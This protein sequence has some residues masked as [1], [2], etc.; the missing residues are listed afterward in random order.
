MNFN[1]DLIDF[2]FRLY[3]FL[4]KKNTHKNV[5]EAIKIVILVYWTIFI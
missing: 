1:D 5:F 3:H 4:T 2:L